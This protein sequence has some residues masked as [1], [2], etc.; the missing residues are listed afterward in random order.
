MSSKSKK[1]TSQPKVPPEVQ[2]LWKISYSPY[3]RYAVGAA[4]ESEGGEVFSGCNVENASYGGTVC[5]ERTAILK[6][7]SEGVRNFKRIFVVVKT[8]H[9]AVPCALCLQ[10]IAEF[11]DPSLEIWIGNTSKISAFFRFGDLLP[12]SFGPK[13]LL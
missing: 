5:A 10:T 7:V 1:K 9:L 6:A 13:D 3:S 11:C 8:P 4:L 12:I 2:K